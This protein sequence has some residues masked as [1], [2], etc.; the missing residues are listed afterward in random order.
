MTLTIN[1]HASE[2]RAPQG[3]VA[4]LVRAAAAGDEA[5]WNRLVESY[6]RRSS[7]HV[8]RPGRSGGRPRGRPG[9][10]GPFPS[11]LRVALGPG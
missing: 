10:A 3:D 7:P 1:P 6:Y 2:R 11:D 5:A 9:W 4:R 8:C